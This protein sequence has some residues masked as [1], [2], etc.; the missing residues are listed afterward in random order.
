DDVLSWFA[1]LSEKLTL[2]ADGQ[3]SLPTCPHQRKLSAKPNQPMDGSVGKRKM[4]VGFV[5]NP[6]AKKDSRCHW[7]Q[8]LVPGELKSSLTAD[9]A[10]E[11]WLDLG[12]YNRVH[13]RVILRDY[14]KPI[15]TASSRSALLAAF[16]R[17]IEGHEL[18]HK[19]GSLHRD[20]SI[21]HLMI[22]ED[23][24]NSSWPAF[25]IDLDLGIKVSQEAASGAKGKTGTRAFM[26]IRGLQGEQHSFMHDLESFFWVLFWICIHYNG[27][28]QSRAV[29]R[30]E[31][32]SYVESSEELAWIKLSVV[33]EEAFFIKTVEGHFT[34]YY[35]PLVPL[36]NQL[37]KLIFPK[38]KAWKREDEKLYI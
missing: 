11:A 3:E 19:A 16:E 13:Q 17:C 18:L 10:L 29:L 12:R 36:M 25:L 2:F 14:G 30:F 24:N 6:Q 4:D 21:N 15:Y 7:S 26:A 34:P 28:H 33:V 22:N 27:P 20:I 32:W 31:R 9:K 8:I 23:V 37:R 38:G 1:G 5:N 35:K